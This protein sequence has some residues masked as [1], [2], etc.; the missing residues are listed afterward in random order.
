VAATLAWSFG[1]PISTMLISTAPGGLAEMTIL[2][3]A[4]GISV[5]LVVA[6]HIFRV[7]IINMG[8]PHIFQAGLWIAAR[9]RKPASD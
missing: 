5:P 2:A 6:F 3:Q 8:T 9:L 4:L 1:L 7:L